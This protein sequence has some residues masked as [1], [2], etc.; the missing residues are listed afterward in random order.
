MGGSTISSPT[1]MKPLDMVFSDYPG[2]P[3]D[4]HPI[5]TVLL[6]RARGY[7]QVSDQVFP[8]RAFHVSQLAAMGQSIAR[9]SQGCIITQPRPFRAAALVGHDLRCSAALMI[10]AC[11]AQGTSSIADWEHLNRGFQHLVTLAR[12]HRKVRIGGPD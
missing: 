12:K 10:A 8:D 9:T 5:L 6:C 11:I 2:L 1:G 7:K 4:L 3:T